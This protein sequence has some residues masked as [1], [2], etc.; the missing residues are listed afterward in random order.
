M[1]NHS[2]QGYGSRIG[3]ALPACVFLLGIGALLFMSI[4][5]NGTAV[6]YTLDDPY[7]HL[8]LAENMIR[9]HYGVNLSEPSAPASSILW[10]LLLAPLARTPAGVWMPLLFNLGFGLVTA[11]A[12]GRIATMCVTPEPVGHQDVNHRRLGFFA[13]LIAIGLVLMTNLI[14][15]VFTGM[16]HPLQVMLAAMAVLGLIHHARTGKAPAWLWAVLILGPLVRYENLAVTLPALGYLALRGQWKSALISSVVTL[17]LL[18]LFSWFLLQ[19]GQ[20]GMPASVLA[21]SSTVSSGGRLGS[22]VS[23]LTQNMNSSAGAFF[24]LGL[25]GL[26]AAGLSPRRE[27]AERWLAWA[28]GLTVALHL[29]VG[30]FGWFDR[31]EIYAWA[32]L[33]L[34]TLYLYRPVWERIGREWSP[35]RAALLVMLLTLMLGVRYL[36]TQAMTPLAVGNIAQQQ[37]QMHRFVTE[38]W[39]QPV[40]VNDLGWVA[41]RNDHYVLDLWGLASAKTLAARRAQQ[42]FWMEKAAES[43]GV[44]LAMIYTDWLEPIPESWTLVA[45]L[46]CPPP[47]VTAAGL[48]VDFYAIRPGVRGPIED[49]VERFSKTLPP[50]VK[51]EWAEPAAPDSSAAAAN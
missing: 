13:G 26:V 16:E 32:V 48:R 20:P 15:L 19:L 34:L 35:P 21:K 49:A 28:G 41:Y 50:G 6:V 43:H 31:Y 29:A 24:V 17:G 25:A 23:N 38:H 44:D 36:R 45:T 33:L 12:Y 51:I 39:Q 47:M 1:T 9:G 22:I 11:L 7:I 30:R 18:A 3:M 40:A 37:Y 14:G 46:V 10:P 5:R 27:A 8:A 2:G 42:P 4:A